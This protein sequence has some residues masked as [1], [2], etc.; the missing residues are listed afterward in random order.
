MTSEIALTQKKTALLAVDGL[1]KVYTLRRGWLGRRAELVHALH[2]VSFE[3]K[4][5]ETLGVV[6]ESGSG[7]STLG[8]TLLRLVE[9]TFGRIHFDGQDITQLPERHL[10]KLRRRMQIVFQD[11]YTSLNP[12]L[13]VRDIVGE[14]IELFKLARGAEVEER[15]GRALER[16]GLEPDAMSRYPSEFSGGQRQRIAIARALAVD[17]E[18][19]ICDEPTSALDVSMQ[20]QIL[21]LFDELQTERDLGMIFI[22]HDLRVVEL[23]SHR[24]AVLY[25]GRVVELGPSRDIVERRLHPYTRALFEASPR[26]VH[27]VVV[28]ERRRLTL[29]GEPPSPTQP[30]KGC[31]FHPRCPRAEKGKCD[32]DTPSL[33]GLVANPA[34][35]VACFFPG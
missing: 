17:P 34:H 19:L 8:K 22:S 33:R 5:G 11:P 24:I 21:N 13:V 14:G 9:P 15:V 30:P 20:S 6:G 12:R 27:D 23:M 18:L 32:T 29:A 35:R 3:L 26:L 28:P 4:R 25:L 7:K 1:T 31:A 2:G 10:R 16:V